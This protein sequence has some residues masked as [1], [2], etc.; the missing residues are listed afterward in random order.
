MDQECTDAKV[1]PRI[2]KAIKKFVIKANLYWLV[3]KREREGNKR[4]ITFP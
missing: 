3:C 1:V 4:A 2:A